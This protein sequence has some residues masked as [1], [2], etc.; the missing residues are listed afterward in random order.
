[1]VSIVIINY[2]TFQL[3]C[4][5]INSIKKFT[6]GVAYEIIVVDNASPQENPDEFQKSFPEIKLIKSDTNVGFA[7]GN[8]LGINAAQGEV[9]LLLNSDAYFIE[10]TIAPAVDR[11]MELQSCGALTVKLVYENGAY[12]SNAR[13]FRSIRNELLDLIRPL[14]LL[15]PYRKR[16]KLML[17]QY[18]RG[19]FDTECDWISGAFLMM[20]KETIAGL[21]D[22]KLDE[23]FFMYGEDQL[24]GYQLEQIGLSCYFMH[25]ITAVHIANASTS[26]EKLKKLFKLNVKR[27]LEIM[28]IRKGRSL[29]YY[30]FKMIFTCK[31]YSRYG[32][33]ILL[34]KLGVS[35]R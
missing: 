17:N 35:I 18:F 30:A 13:R 2:N 32:L 14:L 25:D 7:K 11:L 33:K 1:M 9:I 15:M 23:R 21:P 29:Y 26:Q 12:Q 6:K 31:E 10:E 24:W 5:C 16:A 22:G 4:Q 28:Q 27:E 34:R 19:D 8:N 20:R 3:T